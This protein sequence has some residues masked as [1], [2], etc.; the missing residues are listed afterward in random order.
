MELGE[1]ACQEKK[2]SPQKVRM[3]QKPVTLGDLIGIF[4]HW[5]DIRIFFL[6]TVQGQLCESVIDIDS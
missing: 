6:T 1:Y 3:V 5:L 4:Y 2:K